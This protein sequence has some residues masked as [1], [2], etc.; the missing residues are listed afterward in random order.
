MYSDVNHNINN[1]VFAIKTDQWNRRSLIAFAY[2]LIQN[3]N[4]CTTLHITK[5]HRYSEGLH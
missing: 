2:A 1:K 3:I 5:R 4:I